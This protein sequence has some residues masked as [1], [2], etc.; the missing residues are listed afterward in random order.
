MKAMN[1]EKEA[2]DISRGALKK[3]IIQ[4]LERKGILHTTISPVEN[5]SRP[6][7]ETRV[8]HELACLNRHAAAPP[9]A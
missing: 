2:G 6:I 8:I 3:I 4:I 5:I 9:A 1:E 7:L